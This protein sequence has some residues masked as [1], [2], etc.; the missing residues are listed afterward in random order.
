MGEPNN[1]LKAYMKKPERIQSVLEYFIGRKLPQGWAVETVDGFYTLKNSKGKI[2]FR[3]RDIISRIRAKGF[4]FCLGLENQDAVNL[5]YPWRVMELDC[6]AYGE[7]IEAIQ[8]RN[9]KG[10]AVYGADDDFKYRY[11]KEDRLEPVLTLTLYW[12][13]K[14]WETPLSL[15]EMVDMGKLPKDLR[16]QFVDYRVNLIH[17][18]SIPEEALQKMDSDLKYVLGI[19]KCTGSR[20]K[21]E[22][23]ILNNREYFSRIPRSAVDVIDV[24]TSIKNIRAHL[25]F[26][27]DQENGEETAD[28]CKALVDIEKHA[29]NRGIR[30]GHKQGIK[31]GKQQGI[32]QANKLTRLLLADGRQEDL[33]RSTTDTL[34]R[35]KLFKEY[36]I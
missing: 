6:R 36:K 20:K 15:N 5:T 16:E 11:K 26:T 21:Y 9:E 8:E 28:M 23:Y 24:C 10:K 13:R 2:S 7:E 30:K 17:M 19:M 4:S 32:D 29:E 22:E 3:E 27:T 1:V 33:I 18:R 14:K 12:G 34:F 31:Q 25:Q 35:K